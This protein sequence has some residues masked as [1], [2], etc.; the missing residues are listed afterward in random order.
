MLNKVFSLSEGAAN[1]VNEIVVQPAIQA[2]EDPSQIG[3]PQA[4]VGSVFKAV[5]KWLKKVVLKLLEI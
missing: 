2:A 3:T 5:V 4:L 1:L